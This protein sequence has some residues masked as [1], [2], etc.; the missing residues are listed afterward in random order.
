[1]SSHAE[2]HTLYQIANAP[3]RTYPFPHMLVHDV[4]EPSL[5]Q[6]MLANLLPAET[7]QPIKQARAVGPGYSD[8]RFV[9]PLTPDQVQRLPGAQAAFWSEFA[10]WLLGPGLANLLMFRFG[11]YLDQR[12]SGQGEQNIYNESMLVDDRTRYSLGPHSDAPTKLVTLLFYLPAD[13]SRSHLGTSIYVPKDPN[14]RCPGG[15]HY[16]FD[17]FDRVTTMPYVPNTLFAFFKNDVSFHGVEPIEDPDCR[18]HLLFYDLKVAAKVTKPAPV[19]P[20]PGPKAT[21]SF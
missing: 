3:M 21:F 15:P 14:F 2:L 13:A 16:P 19:P 4:F 12:F 10:K 7:M 1:M 6:R 17:R 9:F 11:A 5:Y 8:E 20:S 18:R